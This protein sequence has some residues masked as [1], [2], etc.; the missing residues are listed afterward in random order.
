MRLKRASYRLKGIENIGLLKV[1]RLSQGCVGF[2]RS[3]ILLSPGVSS[4]QIQENPAHPP[5]T[6]VFSERIVTST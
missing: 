3:Y 4:S 2:I 6:N 1:G 5:T